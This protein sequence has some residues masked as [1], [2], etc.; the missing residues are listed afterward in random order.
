MKKKPDIAK[1]VKEARKSLGVDNQSQQDLLRRARTRLGITNEEL[2]E[3]L[4][5][6]QP[7]LRSYLAPESAG[8]FRKMGNTD[9]LLL[10]E[11]LAAYKK[12]P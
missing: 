2:A 1:L 8:R 12:K 5:V 9:K 10:R 11:I 4:N 7:T 3:A 6:S